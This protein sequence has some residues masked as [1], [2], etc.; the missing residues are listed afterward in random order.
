[1]GKTGSFSAALSA[2]L[3]A[4]LIIMQPQNALTAFAAPAE[5][6]GGRS[7]LFPGNRKFRQFTV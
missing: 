7:R 3:S 2:V 5:S 4:I 1:M 6:E